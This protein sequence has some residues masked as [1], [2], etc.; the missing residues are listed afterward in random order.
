MQLE[1]FR[2]IRLNDLATL[3]QKTFRGWSTRWLFFK[4]RQ[5][6]IKIATA[7]RRYKV[8]ISIFFTT[9]CFYL[10]DK[11]TV[12][13]EHADMYVRCFGTEGLR[14]LEKKFEFT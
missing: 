14:A 5:A 4:R 9:Q 10:K 7:W 11:K 6:Q 13:C 3:I 8:R 12:I 2:R 1:D